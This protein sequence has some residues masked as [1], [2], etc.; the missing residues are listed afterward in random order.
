M[1]IIDNLIEL[2]LYD[3]G[4]LKHESYMKKDQ[5]NKGG[6]GQIFR[7]IEKDTSEEVI[8]KIP[9]IRNDTIMEDIM[10]EVDISQRD[11]ILKYQ[12]I[13]LN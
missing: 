1:P 12:M 8:V 4:G 11:Y 10:R 2:T 9:L 13:L 5:L 3:S 6:F 7:A